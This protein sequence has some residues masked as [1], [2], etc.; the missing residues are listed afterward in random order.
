MREEHK[1]VRE[2][3]TPETRLWSALHVSRPYST[4]NALGFV[5][6]AST[7]SRP[8]CLKWQVVRTVCAQPAVPRRCVTLL[9]G[10]VQC[11]HCANGL[12]AFPCWG[13]RE[14]GLRAVEKLLSCWDGCNATTSATLSVYSG[15]HT[16]KSKRADCQVEGRGRRHV[17]R[18][19]MQE[20]KVL[21]VQ[22]SALS[23]ACWVRC[24]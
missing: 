8:K 12:A 14:E 15:E 11:L 5:L 9:L 6:A 4:A 1:P 7:K 22:S 2:E 21:T 13:R 19:E 20:V 24:P 3:T 23:I 10:S 17:G 16:V 18:E